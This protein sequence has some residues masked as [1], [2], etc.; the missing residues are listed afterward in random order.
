MHKHEYFV[1]VVVGLILAYAV[2]GEFKMWRQHNARK[3]K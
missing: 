2:Y 3:P 1:Y